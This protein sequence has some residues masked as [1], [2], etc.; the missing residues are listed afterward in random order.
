MP[1]GARLGRRR[2]SV[3][4]PALPFIHAIRRANCSWNASQTSTS[5]P[6]VRIG[7]ASGRWRRSK[8][9]AALFPFSAIKNSSAK[10]DRALIVFLRI[11]A[12]STICSPAAMAQGP[13]ARQVNV[14]TASGERN[15]SRK[16]TKASRPLTCGTELSLPQPVMYLLGTL[17]PK[18]SRLNGINTKLN[19]SE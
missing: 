9:T 16:P 3:S 15:M 12:Y 19:K 6:L 10:H 18:C 7:A 4:R 11:L 1:I 2:A 17:T 14:S 8:H 5:P 13:V